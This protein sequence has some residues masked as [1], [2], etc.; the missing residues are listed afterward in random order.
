VGAL[1][2]AATLGAATFAGAGPSAALGE[3]RPPRVHI[4]SPRPDPGTLP[5]NAVFEG[6]AR[7]DDLVKA[8]LVSIDGGHRA[9]AWCRCRRASV[10][11]RYVLPELSFG[12]HVVEVIARDDAG[13]ERS[14]SRTFSIAEPESA[15]RAFTAGSWWNTPMPTAAPVDP[16]SRYWL[17]LINRATGGDPLRLT[18]LPS[19]LSGQA[20]PVYFSTADDPRYTIDPVGGP[21]VTVRIPRWALPSGADSPKMTVI[22]PTTDQGVGLTGVAFADGTWT[23]LGLDRYWLSSDGIAEDAGGADGNQ[24]HRGA[25]MVLKALR[26]EEVLLSPIQRRAQCFVPPDLVG[27]DPVW[28]MVGSDGERRGGIPEGIVLRIRPKVDLRALGLSR[29]A[30]VVATMLQDYGCAVTD[31]GAPSA[32]TLRLSRADWSPTRLRDDSFAGLTWRDWQF[33]EGGYRP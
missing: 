6:R 1:A 23:A 11:W 14:A 13:R 7:D 12:T 18:G 10:R 19:S 4:A 2:L 20:Q 32:V 30:R 16:D 31:G 17:R 25:T 15:F 33:V 8:V 22:D 24:G 28:P 5:Q 21:T 9:P 27:P 3:G 29:D 26:L